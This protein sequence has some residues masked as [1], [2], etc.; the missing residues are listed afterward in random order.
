MR[1]GNISSWNKISPQAILFAVLILLSLG[2]SVHSPFFFK[3][4][5]LRNVLDQS[6][7]NIIFGTGM[8]LVI[9]SGGIDLSVGAEAALAGIIMAIALHAGMGVTPAI[10]AGLATGLLFGLLN[11]SCIAL[12]RLN[13][14]IV[15][16]A[17]MSIIRGLTLILT[18]SIPISGFS[19]DFLWFGSGNAGPLPTT[20]VI[21]AVIALLGAVVLNWTKLG[22]YSTA[23]GGNEEALR[24]SGVS[25]ATYKIALYIL[26]GFTAAVAG[27]VMTARLNS[28]DPT[29]G[30]M[31]EMDAIATA[32]L[33][34][35]SMRGGA[36]SI[37]GMVIA[38]LLLA[39]L[40]NG[41]VMHGIA[42]YYQQLLTG[43][44]I[45]IA[46]FASEM[47]SRSRDGLSI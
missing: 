38:G 3:W 7:L 15:T 13:P 8:T 39:V 11:G 25:T 17:S 46:I 47:R 2:L 43:L 35:T 9:V 32:V 45:L 14:F 29:A 44:I 33:G 27:L 18:G 24:R 30:Y 36:G 10:V 6:T 41:L 21:A 42:S 4:D 1:R 12:L 19:E 28:A 23:L 26:C 20:A 16:L 22:Y 31:M 5:N 40:R 37:G 34:G